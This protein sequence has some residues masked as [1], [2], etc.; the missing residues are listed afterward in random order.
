MTNKQLTAIAAALVI[1]SFAFGRYSVPTSVK[2][3]S[4]VVNSDTKTKQDATDDNTDTRTSTTTT[5]TIKPDGT[6]THT[7]TQETD[8]DHDK[9]KDTSTTDTQLQSKTETKEITRSGARTTIQGLGMVK[10]SSS[11]STLTPDYGMMVTRDVLGPINAGLFGYR[12]GNI[13]IAIGL[14][15]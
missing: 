10:V 6:N 8:I 14:S 13:G 7:V 11:F 15:F 1:V 3:T 4:Q 9:K 2:E 5:D 12:S